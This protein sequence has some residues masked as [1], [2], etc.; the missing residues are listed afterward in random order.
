MCDRKSLYKFSA[1]FLNA[2]FSINVS[3]IFI[4]NAIVDK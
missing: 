4:E 2:F 3:K 1:K